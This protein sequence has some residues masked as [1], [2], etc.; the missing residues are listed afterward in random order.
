MNGMS[1]AYIGLQ[2]GGGIVGYLTRLVTRSRFGHSLIAFDDAAFSADGKEGWGF[3]SVSAITVPT[4]WYT[5]AATSEQIANM[6]T[7]CQERVG[8]PYD[9]AS[10]LKFTTPYRMVFPSREARR[11]RG[12]LFCSEGVYG[13]VVEGAGI[14]LLGEVDAY[15]VAPGH[16]RFSSLLKRANPPSYRGPIL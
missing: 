10:V 4:R 13:C 5:F 8:W 7:W 1:A 15:E 11:D 2:R 16:F 6:A 3:Q 12:K 14:D 9:R